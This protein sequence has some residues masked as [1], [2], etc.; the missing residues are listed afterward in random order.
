M[1]IDSLSTSVTPV[2]DNS[3]VID[4]LASFILATIKTR[5]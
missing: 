4:T 2:F 3:S 1:R 5:H